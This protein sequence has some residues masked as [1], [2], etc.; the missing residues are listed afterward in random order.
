V[1]PGSGHPPTLAGADGAALYDPA[2]GVLLASCCRRCGARHFPQRAVC[3]NCFVDGEVVEQPLSRLGVVRASTVIRVR[4]ALGHEPPYAF[5]S[6]DVD[7][8]AVF[9]RFAGA[10]PER[11]VPGVEVEL[12]FETLHAAALGDVVVHVF[13]PR[14]AP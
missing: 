8:L 9:T 11:F 2:R 1:N 12:G 14:S 6:V 7:G 10:A 13:R 3:P 4:S 5:G